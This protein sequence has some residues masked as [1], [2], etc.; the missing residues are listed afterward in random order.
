MPAYIK[1][2]MKS[3]SANSWHTGLTITAL[4]LKYSTKKNKVNLPHLKRM[5]QLTNEKKASPKRKVM[6]STPRKLKK[7]SVSQKKASSKQKGMFCLIK[8]GKEHVFIM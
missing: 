4:Y 6:K 8:A 7:K 3:T 5:K 1:W 2:Y